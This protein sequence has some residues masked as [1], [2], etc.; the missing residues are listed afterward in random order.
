MPFLFEKI[1]TLKEVGFYSELPTYIK[2]NLNPAF[3]LRP[4]QESAF[5]NYIKAK[6]YTNVVSYGNG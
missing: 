3:E 1:D 2:E 6:A 5:C 4:Y